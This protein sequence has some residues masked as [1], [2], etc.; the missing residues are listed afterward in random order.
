MAF[1]NID[2]RTVNAER[3]LSELDTADCEESLYAFLASGWKYID[4]SPWKDGW[5]IEAVAEHLQAVVDGQIK[6]LLINIPPRCAKS[7]LTSVAFP[8]WT[9]IQPEST[10][11]SGPGV[12]FLCASYGDQLAMRDS[13]KC[14]RLIQSKWYQ[15][16]WGDRFKLA[17]D[18]NVKNRF[19]NDKGGERL[20]TS[21]GAAVTGEGGNCIIV[22]DP[23]AANEAFSDAN[24]EATK[25][26]W[27]GTMSTRLNDQK[28]GAFVVIQQRL[29]ED[30]LSGHILE[31][32]ADDWVHLMLPMKYEAARSY[33]MPVTGWKDPRTV[34]G[35]LL[36]PERF[37]EREIKTLERS[38]G[39]WG[40][41]GQLQQRPEPPGGGIIKNE[42]WQTWEGQSFPPM[43][44]IIATVD[45]AYTTKQTNDASAMSVWGVFTGSPVAVDM[46]GL[47]G[48]IERTY[49]E[50]VP[51]V[52][53]MHAWQGRYEFH[54]LV[55][56]I[57]LTAK[58][59]KVDQVII[60]NKAAGISVSQEMRRVYQNERY[61]VIL[62]DPKSQDK[63]S[64]LYSVQHLFSSGMVYAPDK[65]W[66][67]MMIDQVGKF[68]KG[69]H[70]DLV[71]T[72]SMALR[73]LRD[74]GLL[75]LAAERIED[76]EA[77]KVYPNRGSAVPIYPA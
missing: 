13:V 17:S 50:D 36:W 57:N 41:A 8:A 12:Q 60:E 15:D 16:R 45:T 6:R 42:W 14:R 67:Q 75:A 10:P 26:W 39:Q 65:A 29:A 30:D 20:I 69:K 19:L 64:R 43:D 52:M 28:T 55:E 25:E 5:P 58:K 51:R 68:P 3:M 40:A 53:L 32:E 59:L 61:A 4:P 27:D 18:Q 44:F 71:D 22:D 31:R 37:G 38:L 7:S 2:G 21:V 35:Q 76:I 74:L 34:E 54:E 63:M 77:Q 62:H 24:V 70:D 1:V 48:S 47:D 23:N 56:K 66:A 46:R 49:A 11:T 33:V 9:W 73:H 72:C